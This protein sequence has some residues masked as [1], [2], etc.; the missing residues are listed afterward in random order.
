MLWAGFKHK[1]CFKSGIYMYIPLHVLY[2]IDY[3]FFISSL[4]L[5]KCNDSKE[6]LIDSLSDTSPII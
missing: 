4:F 6:H 3:M 5:S 1:H 2:N